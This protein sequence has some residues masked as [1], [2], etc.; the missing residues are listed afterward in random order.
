MPPPFEEQREY[1]SEEGRAPTKPYRLASIQNGVQ[2]EVTFM[3]IKLFTKVY[4]KLL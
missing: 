3:S 2:H 4:S 1:A